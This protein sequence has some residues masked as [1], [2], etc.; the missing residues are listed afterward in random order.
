VKQLPGA[1]GYVELIYAIQNRMPYAYIKNKAG[2]FIRP[3][4]KSVS[5]A[6]NIHL[7]DDMR[8]S[9]TDTGAKYGYPIA[10]FTWI[11]IYK[12]LADGGLDLV[13]AKAL[14][15]LLWWMTHD[16]QK[17]ARPLHYAPL[18][19]YAKRKVEAIIRSVKYKGTSL[20]P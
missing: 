9:L 20:L 13:K 4:I 19:R 2:N 1:I 3:S 10:G 16:G 7:P 12:D 18:S 8:V 6:S 11:L 17:F 5:L 15:K 14:V